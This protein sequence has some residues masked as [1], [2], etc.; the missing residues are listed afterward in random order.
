MNQTDAGEPSLKRPRTIEENTIRDADAPTFPFIGDFSFDAFMDNGG[1]SS[2]PS[3]TYL[4]PNAGDMMFSFSDVV[5]DM[6]FGNQNIGIEAAKD[7]PA[8]PAEPRRASATLAELP[9]SKRGSVSSTVTSASVRP[10]VPAGISAAQIPGISKQT[11]FTVIVAD[12][13]FRMSWETLC[14]D[15]PINFFV[16]YFTRNPK[17]RTVRIDRDPSTFEIILHYLRGYQIK[18]KDEYQNQN[19][20]NDARYYGLKR[21]LRMLRQTLFLNVG[22]KVFRLSKDLLAKDGPGNFFT[23]P[24]IH[25]LFASHM[26]QAEAPPYMIDR[27]PDTFAEIIEHLQGYSI[28]IRDEVHRANLLKDAQYYSLRRLKDKL[29]T[30]RKTIDGFGET[31]TTEVLLWLK[32]IRLAYLIPSQS[33]EDNSITTIDLLHNSHQIRYKR[34]DITH[35]LLVQISEFYL[36]PQQPGTYRRCQ[37][38]LCSGEHQ[39]LQAIAKALKL[40]GGLSDLACI[41]DDCAICIDDQNITAV[42]FSNSHKSNKL[43]ILRAIVALLAI[44]GQLVLCMIRFEAISSRLQLNL[45]REFLP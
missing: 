35:L 26:D 15:G 42:E 32:D 41:N 29:L 30:A 13:P 20:M 5:N 36:H 11:V 16:D 31:G 14:S 34:E 9:V 39:K 45:K 23:G 19:L 28:E 43:C 10:N 25:H 17:S 24:L 27:N 4:Q 18:P 2:D 21:L 40:N 12:K 44:D 7:I 3:Q 1:M 33:Q 38:E 8:K 37:L 6:T 22:G